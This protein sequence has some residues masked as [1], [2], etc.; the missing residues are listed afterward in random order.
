M[1]SRSLLGFVLV[2][3][4][5]VDRIKRLFF[6]L[7]LSEN[8]TQAKKIVVFSD[9]NF[10]PYPKNVDIFLMIYFCIE[11]TFGAHQI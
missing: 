2:Y 5:T 1:F 7:P 10:R 8:Y 6:G 3:W 4:K 11:M 9:P